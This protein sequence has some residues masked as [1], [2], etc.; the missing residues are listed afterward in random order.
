[1]KRADAERVFGLV[2]EIGGDLRGKV[3]SERWWLIWVLMGVEI[4]ITCSVTQLLVWSGETR[5]FA[6]V[7]LWGLH[8]ALIPPI[9]FFV[10]RRAGG[11]R[12]ATESYIWWIWASFIVCGSLVAVFNHAAGLPLFF[13]APVLALLAAFAFSM[14]AMVTHRLFL[15]CAAFFLLVMVAMSLLPGVQFFIY[16]GSWFCVL[17]GL[18]VF[19]RAQRSYVPHP[20]KAL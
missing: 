6:F 17:A 9:I 18:G 3:V 14:M 13:T 8:V 12:T 16:G 1:M 19:F 7:G 5:L 10:H 15:L 20:S 4:L 11:Q 2:A